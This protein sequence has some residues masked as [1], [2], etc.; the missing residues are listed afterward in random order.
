M[1]VTRHGRRVSQARLIELAHDLLDASTLCAISTTSRAGRP[2]VNTAYFAPSPAFDL[3]WLS[4]PAA[5]HSRNLA[6][7]PATAIAVYD[8]SQRWG[9]PDRGIQLIGFARVAEPRDDADAVYCARFAAYEP[10]AFPA[11]RLYR[12]RPTTLKL[13]DERALGGGGVVTARCRAGGVLEW[14]R[15]DVYAAVRRG[16]SARARARSA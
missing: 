2:H 15:T 16:T 5:R 8:S 11:Y 9:S 14:E 3:V 6:A 10:D 7:H 4:D 12:F 13:F 1:P